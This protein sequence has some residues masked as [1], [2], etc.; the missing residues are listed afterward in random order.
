VQFYDSADD[1]GM[2]WSA[3]AVGDSCIF[4]VRAG[5]LYRSFPMKQADDFDNQP[6]L[7][8]SR[9]ASAETLARHIAVE[10]ADWA[11]DDSF[12]LA[13]DALAAWILRLVAAGQR[14]WSPLG[15]LDT[16][17]GNDFAAWVDDLRDKGE[18][19]NDDTTLVRIDAWQSS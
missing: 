10:S 6:A 17:D 7:L 19:K 1:E 16:D 18:I 11:P 4:Q 15:D 13:T 5:R 3:A 12:Y 8:N 9:A 2:R 14:P